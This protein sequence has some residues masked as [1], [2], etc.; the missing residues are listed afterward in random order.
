MEEQARRDHLRCS[1]ESTLSPLSGRKKTLQWP[2]IGLE[3]LLARISFW[4]ADILSATFDC[5][6]LHQL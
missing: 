6:L 2:F 5:H 1:I 4:N 3:D